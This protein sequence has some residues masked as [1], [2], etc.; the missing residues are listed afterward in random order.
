MY[1]I[2]HFNEC[3]ENRVGKSTYNQGWGVGSLPIFGVLKSGVGEKNNS[4]F[5]L[6]TP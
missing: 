4:N 5:R 2:M 1:T 6:P 3:C